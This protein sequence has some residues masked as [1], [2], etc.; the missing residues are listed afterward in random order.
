MGTPSHSR[1][2]IYSYRLIAIYQTERTV[3][4]SSPLARAE[5]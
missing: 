4:K 5:M 2:D 3:Q 1:P